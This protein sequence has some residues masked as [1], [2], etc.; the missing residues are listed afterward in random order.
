MKL[1]LTLS[2]VCAFEFAGFTLV[3][4]VGCLYSRPFELSAIPG[5]GE[6]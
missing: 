5:T 1:I 3:K 4:A 6:S 2:I